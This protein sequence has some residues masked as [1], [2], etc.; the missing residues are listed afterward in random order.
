MQDLKQLR[1]LLQGQMSPFARLAPSVS[2]TL[3]QI[4]K[5]VDLLR[6]KSWTAA[7][8]AAAAQED[9]N[10]KH[11]KE[12]A[13]AAAKEAKQA[14]GQ[15][16]KLRQGYQLQ[17]GQPPPEQRIVVFIDDLDR[18]KPTKVV[19][20]LEAINMVLCSS[21][22][23]VVVGMVSDPSIWQLQPNIPVG[24]MPSKP[25]DPTYMGPLV[26]RFLHGGSRMQHCCRLAFLLRIGPGPAFTVGT[27]LHGALLLAGQGLHHQRH[28]PRLQGRQ[29][30][31]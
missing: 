13:Q 6:R 30:G 11:A 15:A 21:G 31:G 9:A 28:H 4:D 5:G 8:Q 20:V 18:C 26:L 23:S 27:L 12:A 16:T 7:D 10:K 29:G 1:D 3:R 17:Q 25:L 14:L 2:A 24:C 19:E 22:F